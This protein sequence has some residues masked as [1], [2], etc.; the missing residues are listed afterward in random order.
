MNLTEQEAKDLIKAYQQAIGEDTS[1]KFDVAQ[2]SDSQIKELQDASAKSADVGRMTAKEQREFYKNNEFFNERQKRNADKQ[3]L[4]PEDKKAKRLES[5]NQY[6]Q[7]QKERIEKRQEQKA[8]IKQQQIELSRRE[9]NIQF[10]N[11][12]S[13]GSNGLD[14]RKLDIIISLLEKIVANTQ[15]GLY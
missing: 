6:A 9:P 5:H 13:Q 8:E 2:L 4:S 3:E 12:D 7:V 1:E 14:G 11:Q 10:S 15:T